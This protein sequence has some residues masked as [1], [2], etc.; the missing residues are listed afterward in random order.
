MTHREENGQVVLTMSREE[1]ANLRKVFR[2]AIVSSWPDTLWILQL[3]NC[4]NEGNPRWTRYQVPTSAKL[5][6]KTP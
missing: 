2:S 1:F 5:A 3:E 6:E 4:L